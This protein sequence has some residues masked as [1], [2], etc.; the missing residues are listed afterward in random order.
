LKN[1]NKPIG[2]SILKLILIISMS[3]LFVT[4]K[5]NGTPLTVIDSNGILFDNSKIVKSTIHGQILSEQGKPIIGAVVKIG[6]NSTLTDSI[7]FFL[8]SEVESSAH[9]TLISVSKSGYFDSYRTLL[10]KENSS[11][12]TIIKMMDLGQPT[13]LKSNDGGTVNAIN[14][15]SII[16]KPNSFI[17]ENTGQIYNGDVKVYSK[18]INAANPSLFDLIPGSLRGIDAN[19]F[20]K[21]LTTYG[22]IGVELFDLNGNKLQLQA[23]KKVKI[24][25][26]LD[27][28]NSNDAPSNIPLWHFNKTNG[29]WIQEGS[30]VKTASGY[31]GDVSHFS[32][33]NVDFSGNFVQFNASFVDQNGLPLQNYYIK[34]TN[35]G[36]TSGSGYLDNNGIINGL[37]P[38]NSNLTLTIFIKCDTNLN[39]LYSQS[40]T[41]NTS[42][43]NLGVITVN[44][45]NMNYL[46]LTGIAYD[47]SNNPLPNSIVKI[48]NGIDYNLTTTNS[49]GLYQLNVVSC[50]L[51]I[52]YQAYDNLNLVTGPPINII[53]NSTGAFTNNLFA[54]GN[55]TAFFFYTENNNGVITNYNYTEALNSI[56]H[57]N[58][59]L[60]IDFVFVG[61]LANDTIIGPLIFFDG[62]QSLR[63]NTLST[64]YG[65]INVDNP[66]GNFISLGTTLNITYYGAVGDWI[67]GSF[68]VPPTTWI[69]GDTN[70]SASG[71]FRVKRVN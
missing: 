42:N 37:I 43:S 46:T 21:T 6:S 62:P 7:G 8:F 45:S 1:K 44:L 9:T 12:K 65:S 41:T 22:M 54:C 66:I 67:S 31:E 58:P 56:N 5:K 52:T 14:G 3:I 59:S 30:V 36:I 39:T 28:Q 19:N 29:M 40:I 13:I 16:F 18:R 49:S 60:I 51:Q 69:S 32:Y 50:S 11:Q 2:N 71:S 4:C 23:E 34:V 15:G 27:F 17:N 24:I 70:K 33:W 47:C 25:M 48:V 53:A 64:Q 10:V 61:S 63:L 35:A 20:E 68:S 57:L 26:P 38:E 55:L